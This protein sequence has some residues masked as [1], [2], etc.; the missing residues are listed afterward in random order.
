VT[1][2]EYLAYLRSPWWRARKALVIRFRGEACEYCGRLERL[3]LHHLSYERLGRE[4]PEDVVLLCSVCHQ[5][6]H[7]LTPTKCPWRDIEAGMLGPTFEMLA[8][9]FRT[10]TT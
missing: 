6:A 7:G 9:I 2:E 3:E 4:L 5:R 8:D 10:K 1:H